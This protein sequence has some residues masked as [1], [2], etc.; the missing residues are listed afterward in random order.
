M[1]PSNFKSITCHCGFIQYCNP[2]G[3][4]DRVAAALARTG[5][6]EQRY[7]ATKK[8]L[9]LRPDCRCKERQRRLNRLG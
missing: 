7:K 8:R 4:G 6:T 1:V 2:P 3:L 5:M 9:G